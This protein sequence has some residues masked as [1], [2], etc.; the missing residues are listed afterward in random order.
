M[1]YNQ[2]R[3]SR[4]TALIAA[5]IPLL[6]LDLLSPATVRADPLAITGGFYTLDSPFRTVPRYITFS[7]DLQGT[8]FRAL[9]GELD[10]PVSGWDRTARSLALQAQLSA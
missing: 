2:R 1:N 5:A 3:V 8:G 4:A 9:A 6:V 10:G 7:H